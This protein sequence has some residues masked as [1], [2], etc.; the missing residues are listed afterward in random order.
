[1]NGDTPDIDNLEKER[2]DTDRS[3]DVERV[4][5]TESLKSATDKS[6]GHTNRILDEERAIAD[7]K[8]RSTREHTDERRQSSGHPPTAK[9][10]ERLTRERRDADEATQVER[11]SA[12]LAMN[13]ERVAAEQL[14]SDTFE[15][16]RK[17]TDQNLSSERSSTDHQLSH[18][19]ASLESE[20]EEHSK[21]RTSLTSREELLAI[22]SHDLRNPVGTVSS[23]ASLVL[24]S[25]DL[26]PEVKEYIKAMQRNAD[27]AL[28][29]IEDLMDMERFAQ[30]KWKFHLTE[31][32]ADKLVE[33]CLRDFSGD[34][35]EKGVVLRSDGSL[36]SRGFQCDEGRLTQ[37]LS[38]LVSNAVKF[39]PSGGSIT[40]T[41]EEK[42]G[43]ALFAV[44]DTGT[45]IEAN[46]QQRI[47]ERFAQLKTRSRT[48]L[49][50]GLYIS[51]TLAEAFGGRMWVKSA[52]GA[53][54][55][56]S[57]TIPLRP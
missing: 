12:D 34:A 19:S 18:T 55:T 38:N 17:L 29:L 43:E 31:C 11:T 46:Q 15:Q 30:G 53:G 40:I 14:A 54:S 44:T 8:T 48:G 20:I 37:I 41:A 52:L 25:K 3:L 28:R 35:R 45:G 47:F 57:F 42:D 13:R 16:E 5:A 50:L 7:E 36:P 26:D 49:G 56:F 24:K 51:R 32:H 33:Q 1:M 23:Y 10:S 27:A 9:D 21:T 2:K 39:T 4:K 6:Q 22:V